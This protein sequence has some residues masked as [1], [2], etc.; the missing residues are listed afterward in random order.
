MLNGGGTPVVSG[1]SRWRGPG[2]NAIL[3]RNGQLLNVYHSYDAL[4]AG[5]P[6]LRI[7]ELVWQEGWPISAEP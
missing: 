6:T 7:S 5:M 3:S 1:D 2:H 4:N